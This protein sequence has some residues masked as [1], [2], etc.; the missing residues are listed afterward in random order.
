MGD[1]H[2][3]TEQR[4]LL[5]VVGSGRAED[6]LNRMRKELEAMRS[7]LSSPK[8]PTYHN[9]KRTAAQVLGESKRVRNKAIESMQKKQ[10]KFYLQQQRETAQELEDELCRI[11]EFPEEVGSKKTKKFLCQMRKT[12]GDHRIKLDQFSFVLNEGKLSE[13]ISLERA[14]EAAEAEKRR[15]T[16]LRDAKWARR[17]STTK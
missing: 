7:P 14:K 6:S 3:D 1:I 4:S 8:N 10:H 11:N 5:R 13:Q 15:T 12:I 16:R 9:L 2:L 17:T